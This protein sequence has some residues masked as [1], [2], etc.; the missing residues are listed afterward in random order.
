MLCVVIVYDGSTKK[1]DICNRRQITPQGIY[2]QYGV[3][4]L[5]NQ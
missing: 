3:N 4:Y 5:K 1:D 2:V